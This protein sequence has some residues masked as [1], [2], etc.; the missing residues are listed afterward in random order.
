MNHQVVMATWVQTN[1]KF[2][3]LN[4]VLLSQVSSFVSLKLSYSCTTHWLLENQ[5]VENNQPI[6]QLPNDANGI[7]FI[8]S[9]ILSCI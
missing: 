6:N 5:P 2:E 9:S 1:I 3:N 8:E 7:D 4:F